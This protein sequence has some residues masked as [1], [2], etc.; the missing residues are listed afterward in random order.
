MAAKGIVFVVGSGPDLPDLLTVRGKQLLETADTV[1]YERRAQRKLIPGDRARGPRRVYT[2]AR[3]TVQRAAIPDVARLLVT[4]AR[5]DMRVVF[6]A[7]D[8]P[9]ALGRST[10]LVTALND[11]DVEFELVPGVSAANTVATYAGIPLSAPTMAAA[12]MLVDGSA[13]IET[14]WSAVANTGA[15]VVVRNGYGVVPA[16]VAGF[17]AAGVTGEIPAAA[18]TR[19]GRASQRIVIATLG[20]IWDEMTRSGMTRAATLIIGWTVLLRDELAWFDV[21]PLFGVRIIVAAQRYGVTTLADRLRLLG[22]AVIDVPAPGI[23]R[24]DLSG[25]RAAIEHIIDY[26][27]IVFA[28]PDAVSIFWEHLLLAGRDT[29]ALAGARIACVDPATAAALLDRGVTVD[30]VQPRFGVTALLDVLSER[31]DIPGA[32]LL[33]VAEDATAE[34]TGRDLEQTGAVVTQLA[35]YRE[36]PVARAVQRFRRELTERH[37]ALIVAPSPAAAEDY[38]AAAGEHAVQSIP[39]AVYD[40]ATAAIMRAA[41]AEVL[42]RLDAPN[43]DALIDAI[44]EKFG[45]SADAV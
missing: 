11:A 17:A 27:W 40:E 14:N 15:T 2:G 5:K 21:R 44:R 7:A 41:G 18:I 6:L 38:L 26:E 37:C 42:I 23:A 25:L 4:L 30:V 8:D 13:N 45:S 10:E 32:S 16:I 22:A 9:L 24:L 31:P 3:G 39:A 29:R 12:T 28:S 34:S 1:V 33:Y 35:V 19:A 36:V 20:T 43:I